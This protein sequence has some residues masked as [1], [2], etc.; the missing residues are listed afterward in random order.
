V[1]LGPGWAFLGLLV[2][3]ITAFALIPACGLLVVDAAPTGDV[4]LAAPALVEADPA[5]ENRAAAVATLSTA[6]VRRQVRRELLHV[7]TTSCDGVR[8]GSG[9]ALG[10]TLLVAGRDVVPG[11]AA[12]KIAARNGA[13]R[14]IVARRVYRLGDLALAGLAGRVPRKPRLAPSAPSGTAVAVVGYPLSKSP[15]VLPGVVVDT[16]AGAAF[17]IRG[18]V[19][20]LTS[21]LGHDDPGGPVVDARGRL[22]GIA[23]TTDPRSGLTVAAPVDTLRSVVAAGALEKLPACDG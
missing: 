3:G 15:R 19:V 17:G 5:V 6:R 22:V 1:I 4:R 7:R 9:L 18:K 16:V 10:S 11:A 8:T 21:T 12:V 14:T 23:F 2:A 13:P 20:R